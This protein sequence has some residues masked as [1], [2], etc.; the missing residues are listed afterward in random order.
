MPILPGMY[1]LF[2]V[3]NIIMLLIDNS[4]G[5]VGGLWVVKFVFHYLYTLNEIHDTF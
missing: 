4:I 2:N 5:G 1:D 3:G